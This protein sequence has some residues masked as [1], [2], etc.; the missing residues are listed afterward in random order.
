VTA[1]K[2]GVGFL[3]R[4][5]STHANRGSQGLAGVGRFDFDYAAAHPD[6]GNPDYAPGDA[7]PFGL[8]AGPQG[9]FY[10][11]DG[12]SNT[13]DFVTKRGDISVLAFVP[14]PPGHKPIYDAAP[15]CAARTSNGDVYVG[16]ESNSLYRWNGRRLTQVLRGGKV[17]QV[18]DCI[19]DSSGNIYLANLAS[20]IGEGSAGFIEKPFD[21]SIVKVTPD[22]RTSYVARGLNYPTAMALGPDGHLYVAVNSLCPSNLALLT[23]QN[24]MPGGCPASGKVV[25]LGRVGH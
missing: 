15:T 19:A 2:N 16:T 6:P 10:V 17:G 4:V 13:L 7:D 20:K 5:R 21:G 24:S 3:N 22:R 12:A 1:V 25:R 9:G 18:V 14:D 8:I 23:P 11:V